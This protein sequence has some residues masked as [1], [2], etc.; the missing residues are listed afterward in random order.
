MRSTATAINFKC[1]NG[2]LHVFVVSISSLQGDM[3]IYPAAL[4]LMST[5]E[6]VIVQAIYHFNGN[7]SS[8]VKREEVLVQRLYRLL[9][10][11]HEVD[12]DSCGNNVR[13]PL[14][15]TPRLCSLNTALHHP[16]TTLPS[17]IDRKEA[18]YK[19]IIL[20]TQGY[21]HWEPV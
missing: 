7:T 9:F 20:L 16:T 17:P 6:L 21:Y 12:S 19:I 15:Q 14:R 13:I 5:A 2:K 18:H 1:R 4:R 3:F 10:L 8:Y 11:D